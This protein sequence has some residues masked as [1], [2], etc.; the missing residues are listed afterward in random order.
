MEQPQQAGELVGRA[1]QL[2]DQLEQLP[3][4]A[5]RET[6]TEA[7]A[8]LLDLYGEGFERI[9]DVIAERDDGEV[10]DALAADELVSHLLLLHG[11]HPIPLEDRLAS[12]LAEVRPYLESHGGNVELLGVEDGTVRL[13]LVGSCSGCP[14]SSVTLK[15][16]V[17]N[18]IHRVAPEVVEI[19]AD[20]AEA[21]VPQLLQIEIPESMHGDADD[22]WA[23][24]GG[25]PD[26]DGQPLLKTVAGQELLFIRL[27]GS[28]YAYRPTC[29]C[30]HESVAGGALDGSQLACTACG[31]HFDVMRAGRCLDWPQYNLEPVPLLVD[32]TGLVRV[33]LGAAA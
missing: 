19:V 25:L 30:C 24:A 6:A 9:V 32:E 1:E 27:N 31:V 13:R 16:A 28:I 15:L 20:G 18:A 26:L 14:S 7:I 3:D 23:M 29:P 21:P 11:L 4:S 10:A 12:A 8:A 5:A 17:E 33:A 22:A 2:L